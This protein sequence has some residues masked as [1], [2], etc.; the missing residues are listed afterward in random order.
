M[1]LKHT[2]TSPVTPS[3]ESTDIL[4]DTEELNA[5]SYTTLKSIDQEEIRTDQWPLILLFKDT[6]LE[7][8]F[9]DYYYVKYADRWWKRFLQLR[10]S[11]F[12]LTFGMSVSF[13]NNEEVLLLT[14]LCLPQCTLLMCIGT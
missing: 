10:L 11:L 8:E 13:V 3:D 1:R 5:K 12:F 14:F 7:K 2:S 4:T 6:Q 9:A